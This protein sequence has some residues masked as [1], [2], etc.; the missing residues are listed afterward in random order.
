[1]SVQQK[2]KSIFDLHESA[3]E[4]LGL[5]GILE[6][7]TKSP[8]SLGVSLSAFNLTYQ[9]ENSDKRYPLESLFQ[10][11]KVFTDGGPYRDILS[12]PARE[13]KSDPRLTT[14]GRLVAFSSRDTTWPL[15]PRTA[16]YDWLYLN[17]LG[18]YPRLAEP[19]SMF[20]GFTDIEFNPKKSINCQAY[21][22]ALFVALSE[23][24]LMAKAMKS[25]A[26]F[27]ETLNE[28]SASETTVE[29][30]G[31]YSLFDS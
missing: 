8:E 31:S 7:S 19:L 15:V 28:F 12:K 4:L 22:A 2:Q 6:I 25:K 20:G 14:S 27:L 18:H 23:R 9:P 16:F 10:S 1:M 26:A 5:E 24:K 29:T 30:Q 11:A 3:K 13:A 21:S 17:V